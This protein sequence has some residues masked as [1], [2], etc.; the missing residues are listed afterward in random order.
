MLDGFEDLTDHDF[1]GIDSYFVDAF[2]FDACEGQ[3]VG[4]LRSGAST[5]VEMS[6]EPG[7]GNFHENCVRKRVSFSIR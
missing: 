3:E 2:H 6:A 5:E 1:I 7:E 4:E